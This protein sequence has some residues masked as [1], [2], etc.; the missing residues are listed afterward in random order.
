MLYDSSKL[1]QRIKIIFPFFIS[2]SI[3]GNKI[4]IDEKPNYS[5][6]SIHFLEI[7]TLETINSLIHS[8]KVKNAYT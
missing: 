7:K 2:I 6:L 5:I 1:K 3:R 4:N 8:S